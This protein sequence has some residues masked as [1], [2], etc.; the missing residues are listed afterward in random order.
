MIEAVVRFARLLRRA[1][2]PVGP[3][4]VLDALRALPG[5]DLGRRDDVYW[6]LA[7]LFVARR[8]HLEIF[9][10]AFRAFWRAPDAA[11]HRSRPP[12]PVIDPALDD[13]ALLQ[14]RLAEALALE[15][16]DLAEAPALIPT[17][18]ETVLAPSS[19]EA[20][21]KRDFASMSLA[22]LAEVRDLMKRL[23]LPIPPVRTRRHEPSPTHARVDPRATLRESLRGPRELIPLR[24]CRPRERHVP[25]VVLC[26]ISGSMQQYTRMFLHFLH[27]ITNDRD[28]VHVFLFGT[29]LT[30]ITRQLRHRD[31]DV[32]L[33]AVTRAVADWSAGTRIGASLA[34]FN[35]RWSRRV[36]GQNAAV[37]LITDGLD[38]D[39]GDVLPREAERLHKSCRH[40]LWLNPL[41][42]FDG[43]E[44][45]AA[46]I[47]LLLPHVDRFLPAHN[48][49]S[50]AQVASLLTARDSSP[51]NDRS[52]PR[53]RSR[54]SN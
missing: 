36:L 35:W 2:L 10:A 14:R 19:Q 42:R 50:L 29:R 25:L 26:D 11:A 31:A 41:L 47:R 7:A 17:K 15:S 46:G 37:L 33:A 40:L 5:V 8:E 53:W 27:A 9:D 21:R 23:R 12:L 13:D 51:L 43:F 34:E 24:H 3:G 52:D 45:R 16:D 32:A 39:P 4:R 1:G 28:R 38:R 20:L 6:T 48:V 54:A 18:R 49:D 30:N 44:P 22:E